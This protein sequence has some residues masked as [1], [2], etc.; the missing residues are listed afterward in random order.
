[1]FHERGLGVEAVVAHLTRGILR[2]P[3][4]AAQSEQV[5][6]NRLRLSGPGIPGRD[7]PTVILDQTGVMYF[8]YNTWVV[9]P[10]RD[11][12]SDII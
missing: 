10:R 11:H 8:L 9:F 4:K 2:S 7:H 5:G 3:G 1:M 6:N 12:F